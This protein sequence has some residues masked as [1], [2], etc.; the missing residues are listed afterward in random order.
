[1]R[2][3]ER[4]IKDRAEID[5]ILARAPVVRIAMVDGGEPYV[6]P[7][8][9]GYEGGRIVCHSAAGGRKIA[10]LRRNPRVCFEATV[11]EAVAIGS[12]GCKSSATYRCVMGAGTVRFIEDRAEK[13]RALD[14]LMRKFA[15]GPFSYAEDDLARTAV[16]EIVIESVSGKKAGS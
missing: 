5:A 13:I 12:I 3:A 11:D 1:V 15:P 16:F 10:V 8:H 6:V 2:R 9:F 14:A 4:E 7:M